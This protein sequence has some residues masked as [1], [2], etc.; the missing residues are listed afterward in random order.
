[1]GEYYLV[2]LE[3]IIIHYNPNFFEFHFQGV[4][5][6]HVALMHT[7]WVAMYRVGVGWFGLTKQCNSLL[8]PLTKVSLLRGT[9]ICRGELLTTSLS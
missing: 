4:P 2:C 9:A 3:Y 7:F 8:L 1:M 5:F 6:H